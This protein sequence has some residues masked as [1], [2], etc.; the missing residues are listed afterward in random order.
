MMKCRFR[1][2]PSFRHLEVNCNYR[3]VYLRFQC[4]KGYFI[5]LHFC[6]KHKLKLFL[7]S[8]HGLQQNSPMYPQRAYL[9]FIYYFKKFFKWK[10]SDFYVAN[11]YWNFCNYSIFQVFN[12]KIP[13]RLK[14]FMFFFPE[15][16]IIQNSCKHESENSSKSRSTPVSF[17]SLLRS[18][19]NVWSCHH[20]G[21]V[22]RNHTP[23]FGLNEYV[24][25]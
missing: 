19:I 22:I 21:P 8:I 2:F 17:C 20:S 5:I 16:L 7:L 18:G 24:L 13:I 3:L 9:T 15:R 12:W 11:Q 10:I 14:S 1:L 23:E 25:T 6:V 4:F